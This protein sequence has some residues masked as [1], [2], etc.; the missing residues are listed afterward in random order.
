[1]INNLQSIIAQNTT[2][3]EEHE[4]KDQH[5]NDSLKRREVGAQK[6]ATEFCDTQ[7]P[8]ERCTRNVDVCRKEIEKMERT[9]KVIEEKVINKQ[10]SLY[11]MTVQLL[12]LECNYDIEFKEIDE[13]LTKQVEHMVNQDK[14]MAEQDKQL[15]KQDKQLTNHTEQMANHTEQIAKQDEQMAKQD[16]LIATCV[17]DIDDMKKKPCDTDD[18]QG[19]TG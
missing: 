16:E 17:K 3:K 15:T 10:D 13:R 6:V 7:G 5:L 11:D 8:I 12:S 9:I 2:I 4:L 1:M 19:K 18:S 14:L